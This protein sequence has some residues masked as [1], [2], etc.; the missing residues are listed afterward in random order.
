SYAIANATGTD[1]SS[2]MGLTVGHA[3]V[4]V[5][6]YS[7]EPLMDAIT[8]LADKSLKWYGLDIAEPISAADVLEVAAFINATSP[9]RISGQTITNSLSLDGTST[10]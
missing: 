2:L 1:V 4:P 6:G 10:S 9:S 3:S 8:H 5:N 7:S